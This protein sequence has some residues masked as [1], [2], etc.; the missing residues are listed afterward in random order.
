L[1]PEP[2]IAAFFVAFALLSIGDFR[3][4]LKLF[5]D[6]FVGVIRIEAQVAENVFEV[7]VFRIDMALFT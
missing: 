7:L 4:D 3:I 6:I 5:L 2:L 1:I